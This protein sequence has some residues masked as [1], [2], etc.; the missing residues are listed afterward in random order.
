MENSQHSKEIFS[1]ESKSFQAKRPNAFILIRG[2][3]GV[4]PMAIESTEI[5]AN[6]PIFFLNFSA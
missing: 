5:F 3:D 4:L 1:F 2:T 6:L